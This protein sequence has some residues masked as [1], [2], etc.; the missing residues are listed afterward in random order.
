MIDNG[1]GTVTD[2][3]TGLMWE[4]AGSDTQ[5]D[6]QGAMSRCHDLTL[7]GYSDWRLPTIQELGSII[8]Y[9][10]QDPAINPAFK[11]V[12]D[13]YWSVTTTAS[14]PVFAWDVNFDNGD[15]FNV[16][17]NNLGYV[18]AVRGSSKEEP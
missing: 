17:K 8:D 15:V 2:P 16:N 14:F 10:R 5:H 6:H 7:A 18:R 3:R 9:G 11:A 1:D 12:A 4:Q 13:N